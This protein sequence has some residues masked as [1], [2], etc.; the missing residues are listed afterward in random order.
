MRVPEHGKDVFVAGNDQVLM[1]SRT[2]PR[3]YI[4]WQD[5]KAK[6]MLQDV[7]IAVVIP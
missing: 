7:R 5:Q 4:Y 3:E 6:L 1:R 2:I